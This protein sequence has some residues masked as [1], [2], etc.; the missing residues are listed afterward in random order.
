MTREE[1]IQALDNAGYIGWA[2]ESPTP[3]EAQG[4][5]LLDGHFTIAELEAIIFLMRAARENRA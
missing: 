5:V 1:A 2:G 4:T 3:G